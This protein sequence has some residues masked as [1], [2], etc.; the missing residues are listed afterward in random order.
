[1]ASSRHHPSCYFLLGGSNPEPARSSTNG[2]PLFFSVGRRGGELPRPGR[3]EGTPRSRIQNPTA[4]CRGWARVVISVR[5]AKTRR[6]LHHLLR[7]LLD[8]NPKPP[9]PFPHHTHTITEMRR[10]R[11]QQVPYGARS[12]TA[13]CEASF[14]LFCVFVA[15]LKDPGDRRSKEARGGKPTGTRRAA[16]WEL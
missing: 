9:L 14:A 3:S 2:S 8:A 11:K 15:I 7:P 13:P 10:H 1:M 4:A 5:V 6:I 12:K 16:I